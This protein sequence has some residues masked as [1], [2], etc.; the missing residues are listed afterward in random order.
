MNAKDAL[1]YLDNLQPT[2]RDWRDPD[3][4]LVTSALMLQAIPRRLGQRLIDAGFAQ[5]YPGAT[6]LNQGNSFP[7]NQ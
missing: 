7:A 6:Q 1:N 3:F 5:E 2:D 4:V